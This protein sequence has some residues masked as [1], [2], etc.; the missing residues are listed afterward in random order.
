MCAP[1]DRSLCQ[2]A[3]RTQAT[4]RCATCQRHAPAIQLDNPNTSW[5]ARITHYIHPS[6][7]YELRSTWRSILSFFTYSICF[8]NH[9]RSGY[10]S[11]CSVINVCPPFNHFLCSSL[12]VAI[13]IYIVPS[14]IS[15]I[16][17]S[18]S[19]RRWF[20]N[21]KNIQNCFQRLSI[22]IRETAIVFIFHHL[23]S[24]PL[25]PFQ[26]VRAGSVWE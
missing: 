23:I 3:N 2:L 21:R 9:H 25:L 14:C 8:F 20:Y 26:S 4:G 1:F 24:S 13:A 18:N 16:C 22:S 17:N 11:F 19:H 6:P 15:S 5:T 10:Y 12:L 7:H